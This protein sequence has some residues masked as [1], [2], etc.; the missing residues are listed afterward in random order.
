M[1]KALSVAHYIIDYYNSHGRAINIYKLQNILYLVQAEFLV[2]TKY[3]RPCFS[4]PIEAWDFG[5][6]IPDVHYQYRRF[7]AGIIIPDENDVL[8]P[9][10]QKITGEDKE[11]I[12]NVLKEVISCYSEAELRSLIIHQE[13]WK[14]ANK[15]SFKNRIS[16]ESIYKYFKEG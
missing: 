7:G 12:D 9:Y 11:R 1:Y 8:N 10:Y 16:N 4:D 5:V 13:P 15:R 14:E 3:H 2:S 6:I